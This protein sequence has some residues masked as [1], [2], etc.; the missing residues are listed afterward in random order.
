[1]IWCPL[2][3]SIFYGTKSTVFSDPELYHKRSLKEAR[4]SKYRIL[5]WSVCQKN[6]KS[7]LQTFVVTRN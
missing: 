2:K 4:P 3:P 5:N 1:M 7:S 6:A